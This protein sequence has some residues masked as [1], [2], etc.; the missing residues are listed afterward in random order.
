[1]SKFT[2]WTDPD[3][4]RVVQGDAPAQMIR[5]NTHTEAAATLA[6]KLGPGRHDVHVAPWPLGFP[7]A[8]HVVTCDVREG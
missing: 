7:C 1:M 4:I 3:P 8:V 5:A 2:C 6:S